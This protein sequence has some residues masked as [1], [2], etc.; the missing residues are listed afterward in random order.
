MLFPGYT[1]PRDHG[2]RLAQLDQLLEGWRTYVQEPR[3]VEDGSSLAA[4]DRLFPV[5]TPSQLAWHGIASAV[6]HLDM[7]MALLRSGTSHPLAP[8][9]IARTGM[10]S[11]AHALWLLDGPDRVERQRRGLRLAHEEFFRDHQAVRDIAM[12]ENPD[13]ARGLAEMKGYLDTR[14]EWMDRAV[15]VGA[16]IGMPAK[17]VK[18]VN[19]TQLLDT[20]TRRLVEQDPEG[21]DLIRAVRVVWRVYSGVAHGLRWPVMYRAQYGAPVPGG[22]PG[23]V[24]GHVTNSVGDLDMAASSVSIFLLN[25]INLFEKRRRPA[26]R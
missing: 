21:V 5:L 3:S 16:T 22:K 14:V 13:P 2:E 18:T 6:D 23:T 1:A 24:E 17:Q 7:F 19:D 10:L 8:N 26:Q 9:T 11:G 15:A 4:D 12:I 20:V 25:A